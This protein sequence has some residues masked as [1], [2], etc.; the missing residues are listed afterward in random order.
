MTDELIRRHSRHSSVRKSSLSVLCFRRKS[1]A[2]EMLKSYGTV[3]S[4]FIAVEIKWKHK[5]NWNVGGDSATPTSFCSTSRAQLP[6]S[7]S[8]TSL[9]GSPSSG[10]DENYPYRYTSGATLMAGPPIAFLA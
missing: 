1:A 3:Y 8:P 2:G 10:R 7:S 6:V 4:K 5:V 9:D